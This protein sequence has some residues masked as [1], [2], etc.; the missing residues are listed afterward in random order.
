MALS[1]QS[2]GENHLAI[3]FRVDGL[4][5]FFPFFPPHGAAVHTVVLT[6]PIPKGLLSNII[7]FGCLR[8]IGFLSFSA[9]EPSFCLFAD[10]LRIAGH[11]N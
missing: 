1:D 4:D 11:V 3:P 7:F 2:D 10:G 9:F 8:C 6:R 5:A